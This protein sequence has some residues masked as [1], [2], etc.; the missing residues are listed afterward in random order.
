M[1]GAVEDVV[2]VAVDVDDGTT[3]F[4]ITWGRI[5]STVDPQPLEELVLRHAAGFDLG[6][7]PVRARLCDTLQEARNEPYFFEALVS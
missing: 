4:F 1:L 6:G 5:Q 7:T 3:R 2:A